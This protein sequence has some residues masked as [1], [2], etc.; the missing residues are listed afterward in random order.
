MT[1]LT[2]VLSSLGGTAKLLAGALIPGAGNIDE[3][4]KAGES[5]IAAFNTTKEANGGTAPADAEESHKLLLSKV[6]AHAEGTLG[7][8]EGGAG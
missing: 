2:T 4:V 6:Q 8:L 3:L 5:I 7:R 1:I